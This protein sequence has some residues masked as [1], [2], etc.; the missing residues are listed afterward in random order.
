MSDGT[1]LMEIET[2]YVSDGR[3]PLND[4]HLDQWILTNPELMS[5]GKG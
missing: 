1:L 3:G 2:Y 4:G 5:N